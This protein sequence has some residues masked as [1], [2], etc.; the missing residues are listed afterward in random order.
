[1]QVSGVQESLADAVTVY[2][3]IGQ[4]DVQF[5]GTISNPT[6]DPVVVTTVPLV[7]DDEIV[8]T[9]TIG[10]VEG[11]LSEGVLVTLPEPNLPGPLDVDDTTVLVD[12]IHPLASLVTVYVNSNGYSVDPLGQPSVAVTVPA[13][14]AGDQVVATQTIGGL[15]SLD[16]NI[17]VVANFLVVN[18]FNYDDAST[19]DHAF[20][21][22]YNNSADPIDISGHVIEIGDT[23]VRYTLTI[24]NGTTIAGNGY[25]T[26]GH[27][28]VAGLPGAVV[29]VVDTGLNIGDTGFAA[30]NAML[31]IALRSPGG[32]LLDAAAV[33]TNKDY[34]FPAEIWN[35]LGPGIWGNHVN[36]EDPLTSQS[37][38]LDGLDTNNNGRDFGIQA[39]TPGYS[40]NQPELAPYL[41]DANALTALDPVP[42]WVF[43]YKP[44]TVIDPTVADTTGINP[45]AI[46]A[47]PDGGNAMI[48]WDEEGGGNAD[49]LGTLAHENFTLETYIYI[50]PAYTPN[51]YEELKLGIRGS[52]DGV[53]NFDYYNGATGVCWFL[54]RT[55]TAQTLYLLDE[56]D[57]DDGSSGEAICATILG[58]IDIGTEPTMT[59]WQRLLIET[60]GDYVRGIFGG[61][62]GSLTDGIQIVGE[63]ACPGPGGVYLS[64][65]EGMTGTG[66]PDNRPPTLDAITLLAPPAVDGDLDQDGDVDMFDAAEFQ[67]CF[68]QTGLSAPCTLADFD[69]NDAIELDDFEWFA[70][71]QNGAQ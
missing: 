23:S 67:A 33:E 45:A 70:L 28:A 2:K 50:A 27:T 51:G 65:R 35:E 3:L 29:D 19:D 60:R 12:A 24:A 34:N 41:E 26:V 11:E 31:Y 53:H 32:A 52:A 66:A 54:Q 69:G 1:V 10:G 36:A 18:E 40:N 16:S 55:Q 22:L 21:E 4:G 57:G 9:Q 44:L 49:Y 6:T 47:S 48:G 42:N 58:Q 64:Y 38:F 56:N 7:L 37:R 20:I 39:A 62:Y 43:S 68:G 59:G 25:W 63:H 30:A 14:V 46:P 71:F 8:A 13:L 5:L 15:E 61:T 17:L